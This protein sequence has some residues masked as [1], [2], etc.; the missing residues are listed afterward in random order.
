[1]KAVEKNSKEFWE[2]TVLKESENGF[3]CMSPDGETCWMRKEEYQTYQK[4]RIENEFQ[5]YKI[6]N[7]TN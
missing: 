5:D 7:Q 4:N 2:V 3:L 1:M 6:K